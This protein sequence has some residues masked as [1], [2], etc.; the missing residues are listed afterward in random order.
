MATILFTYEFGGGYGH[1]N[2]LAEVAKNLGSNHRLVFAVPDPSVGRRALEA[3][4]LKAEIVQGVAW[5]A[6]PNPDI[7]RVPTYTFADAI[8][9]FGYNEFERLLSKCLRWA[10][11]LWKAAP[12]LIVADWAPTVR[13]VSEGRVPTVTLGNGYTVPPRGQPLPPIRPWSH[14]LPP[15]SRYNEGQLL[16]NVN[17]VRDQFA[18][19]AVHFFA[20]LFHGD[21]TFVCT[22][23]EFDPYHRF[24][25]Q[26]TIWPFNVPQPS[27]A[28]AERTNEIFC[29]LD[30]GHPALREVLAAIRVLDA[31]AEI[32][33]RGS[34][35]QTIA[36]QCSAKARIHTKPA[37]L[38]EVLP[39]THAL[40]HHAGL[41]TA[42][43]GLAAAVPQLVL[44]AQ[45]E[46]EV[47]ARGL[48]QF[49]CSKSYVADTKAQHIAEGL[50]QL[51]ENEV[52]SSAALK[53][54]TDLAARRPENPLA[55][56][57]E[58]CESFL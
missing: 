5:P 46:H 7:R 9:L 33:I 6:L 15:S 57:L 11:L 41:G 35:P 14:V 38:A 12:D 22:I 16:A 29:Y 43:A 37:N 32:Y 27:L 44:P 42:Y 17:R 23:D 26:K 4:H 52:F 40:I 13:I 18:G 36:Q 28:V 48:E 25:R 8:C 56:I 45:L 50:R 1:V 47:T 19:R 51:L 39:A 30:N 24:R 21:K 34:D 10:T 58:A 53:A 49:Q 55:P 54:Q 20:D 2:R 3:L 31:K